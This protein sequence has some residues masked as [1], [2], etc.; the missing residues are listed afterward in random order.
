MLHG[1]GYRIATNQVSMSVIDRR[2]ETLGMTEWCAANDVGIL[3]YATLLGGFISDKW[4][5]AP[6][7]KAEQLGNW[8][9]KK[10]KR[11]ID[12]AGE[13]VS[14]VFGVVSDICRRAVQTPSVRSATGLPRRVDSSSLALG[15]LV[16]EDKGPVVVPGPQVLTRAATRDEGACTTRPAYLGRR[17]LLRAKKPNFG[18]HDPS[19]HP[20]TSVNVR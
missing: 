13:C 4:V 2:A 19:T 14:G 9:L 18:T 20:H 8:S 10:Y 5:G 15:N 3:A 11:F 6:E 17:R 12:V 16:A 7:P 1:S